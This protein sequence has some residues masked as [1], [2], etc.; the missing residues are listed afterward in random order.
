MCTDPYIFINYIQSCRLA[1]KL[2]ST[3]RQTSTSF[4]FQIIRHFSTF[5]QAF[6]KSLNDE[7]NMHESES[8]PKFKLLHH[9]HDLRHLFYNKFDVKFIRFL[10]INVIRKFINKSFQE[11]FNT[12]F[13]ENVKNQYFKKLVFSHKIFLKIFLKLIHL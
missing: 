9:H 4:R 7:Q 1:S 13:I 2:D 12:T 3:V 5:E 11:S 6:K 8:I 10:L